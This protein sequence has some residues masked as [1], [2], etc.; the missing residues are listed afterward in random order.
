MTDKPRILCVDDE[1]RVLI[2]LS[3]LLRREFDVVTAEV[4]EKAIDALGRPPEFAVVVSDMRMPGMSGTE[5]LHRARELAPRTTRILLSGQADLE[6]AMLAVN[7]AGVFRILRKPCEHPTLLEALRAGV[8]QYQHVVAERELRERTLVGTIGLLMDILALT[9]PAA[10]GHA[11]QSRRHVTMLAAALKYPTP[12]ELE[13]AS[14]LLQLGAILLTP[15]TIDKLYRGEPLNEAEVQALARGPRLVSEL[16]HAV[17][18]LD[19][20]QRLVDAYEHA[21]ELVPAGTVEL[22]ADQ[23]VLGAGVLRIAND[24]E[25]LE[26]RGLKQPEIFELLRTKPRGYAQQLV[27]LFRATLA[28]R[29]TNEIV[30]ELPLLAL[31]PG[32]VLVEDLRTKS[33]ASIARKGHEINSTFFDNVRANR[34]TDVIEPVR[35]IVGRRWTA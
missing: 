16:F 19:G 22:P 17:P 6:S 28:V 14:M 5:L 9:N 11:N 33:G 12:W 15:T 13:V 3:V 26:W 4:P 32:M 34:Y 20:V 2:G 25:R 24:Y 1:A 23:F 21:R 8:E 7:H 27:E 18:H 35:V 30:E 29:E 10:F 31:R